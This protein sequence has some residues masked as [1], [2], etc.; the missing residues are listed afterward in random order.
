MENMDESSNCAMLDLYD[1]LITDDSVKKQ[2]DFQQVHVNM[3]KPSTCH[4]SLTNFI[5]FCSEYTSP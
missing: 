1:D 4:K 2:E 5:T 3:R